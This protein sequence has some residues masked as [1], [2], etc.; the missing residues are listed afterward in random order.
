MKKLGI[1][2]TSLVLGASSVALAQPAYNPIR[3]TVPSSD[4]YRPRAAWT[5][6]SSDV[7]LLR[8]GRSIVDVSTRERFTKLKLE[9]DG[10]VAV[11]RLVIVF[12]N[13]SSQNVDL[14]NQLAAR[15]RFGA[16]IAIDLQGT[17]GRQIDK[18]FVYGRGSTH[19]WRS[20]GTFKLLAT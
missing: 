11:D 2:I 17:R 19:G 13:G 7:H 18:I 16:P 20:A 15:R 10:R 3:P 5:A 4:Y 1:L 14:S 8:S 6:L 9:V 12:A